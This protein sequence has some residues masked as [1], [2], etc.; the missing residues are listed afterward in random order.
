MTDAWRRRPARDLPVRRQEFAFDILQLQRILRYEVPSPLPDAP[1]FLE[2]VLS[3]EGGAVPVVDLRKRLGL[4][5]TV[6][7]ETRVMLLDARWAP[8]GRG[9]GCGA[10]GGA[11]GQHHHQRAAADGAGAGG[12]STSPASWRGP[13]ARSSS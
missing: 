3:Y 5:A 10:R 12:A 6:T 13:S 1:D 4:P 11:G 2:G 9:G 8:G 7:E